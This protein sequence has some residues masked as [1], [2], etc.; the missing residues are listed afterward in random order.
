M[1]VESAAGEG[2]NGS[3]E[4][5]R[6]SQYCHREYHMNVTDVAGEDIFLKKFNFLWLIYNIVLILGV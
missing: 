2:S 5:S 1:N 6:E 3:E 4:H